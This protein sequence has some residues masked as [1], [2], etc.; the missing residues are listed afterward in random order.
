MSKIIA[1]IINNIIII[2]IFYY[3]YYYLEMKFP[4]SNKVIW[5]VS[6]SKQIRAYSGTWFLNFTEPLP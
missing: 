6:Y 5:N 3:D 1:I 2:T 4:S